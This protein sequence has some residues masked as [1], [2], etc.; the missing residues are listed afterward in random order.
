MI[1]YLC[2][3]NNYVQSQVAQI[4]AATSILFC[5][6][7]FFA[8]NVLAATT[9][10]DLA[11]GLSY[12]QIEVPNTAGNGKIHAFMV[13]LTRNRFALSLAKNAVGELGQVRNLTEHTH[14]LVGINGGFFNLQMATLGLR[15]TDGKTVSPYKATRWWGTFQIENNRA[16]ILPPKT[17]PAKTADFAVQ[18]GPRLLVNK[19]IP[20]LSPGLDNRSALGIRADG[21]VIIAATENV[22]LST[23]D[24]ANV[25]RKSTAENGLACKDAINLDGGSSTQLYAQVGD[26]N[27]WIPSFMPVADVIVVLP[28]STS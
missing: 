16:T 17:Q 3:K 8:G 22:N 26:F 18:A 20:N 28:R 11:P 1:K 7:I 19:T 25:M 6:C 4:S 5:F 10:K 15:I 2:L 23:T 24:L 27:L 14:G 12:A 21:K 13:D 9:W